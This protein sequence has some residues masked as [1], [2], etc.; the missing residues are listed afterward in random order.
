M[1]WPAAKRWAVGQRSTVMRRGSSVASVRRRMP[2]V[3]LTDFCFWST[4][5]RR[6]KKSVCGREEPTNSS[7]VTGPMISTGSVSGSVV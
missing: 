6:T 1:R 4:S 2:S 3:M 7:A 5:H